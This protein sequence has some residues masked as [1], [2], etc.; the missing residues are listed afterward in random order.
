MDHLT[1]LLKV[2]GEFKELFEPTVVLVIGIFTLIIT[3][4]SNKYAVSRERVEYVYHPLFISIEP[5]L[6]KNVS[7]S[8]VRPFLD[9]FKEL[10]AKYSLLI[11][12][13][14]RQHIEFFVKQNRKADPY[15]LINSEWFLICDYICNDYDKL[16]RIAHLPVRSTAYRLNRKQFKTKFSLYVATL[17]MLLPNILF[18]TLIIAFVFP[19]IIPIAYLIVIAFLLH[20]LFDSV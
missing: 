17:K 18:I 14:L 13:S 9:K 15:D 11:Y 4:N 19:T 1:L 3:K 6:Y 10:D 8:D 2:Y 16:C 20:N 7:P 5:Y 12:P